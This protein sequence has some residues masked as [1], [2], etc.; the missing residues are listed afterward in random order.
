MDPKSWSEGNSGSKKRANGPINLESRALDS[1]LKTSSMFMFVNMNSE[2]LSVQESSLSVAFFFSLFSLLMTVDLFSHHWVD[3][4]I[5]RYTSTERKTRLSGRDRNV[6]YYCRMF[7]S[8]ET[9]RISH[10]PAIPSFCGRKAWWTAIHGEEFGLEISCW[11]LCILISSQHDILHLLTLL[12]F[13][14]MNHL[15]SCRCGC[16]HCLLLTSSIHG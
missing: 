14:A 12:L 8:F 5:L 15:R 16:L 4:V 11:R 6:H 1:N 2:S 7:Q 10:V 9:W 13:I 3:N